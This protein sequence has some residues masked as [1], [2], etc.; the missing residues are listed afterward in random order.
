MRIANYEGRLAI[1]TG[2]PGHEVAYD[3][4]KNSSGRFGWQPQAV[5]ENWDAFTS[6]AAGARLE[7]ATPTGR[8]SWSPSSAAAPT[9]S[10]DPQRWL[11]DG[12]ILTSHIEGIGGMR[13]RFVA[14]SP[15]RKEN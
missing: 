10:R 12:D 9:G 1:V 11:S 4:E 14:A 2:A 13:H 3:V 8:S 5:Y 6:W 7:G 15:V